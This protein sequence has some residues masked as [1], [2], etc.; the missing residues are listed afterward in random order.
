MYRKKRG[1]LGFGVALPVIAA[2]GI[3]TPTQG[4][5]ALLSYSAK[6]VCGD[7]TNDNIISPVVRGKYRTVINI[8]NPHN[9]PSNGVEFQKKAVIALSQLSPTPGTISPLVDEALRPDA[10][11]GVT[12]RDICNLVAPVPC[13]PFIEGFLV[14]HVPNTATPLDVVTVITGRSIPDGTGPV[15][16]TTGGGV[17]TIDFEEV[18]PKTIQ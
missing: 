16:T 5:A 13:V 10:A 14:I 7:V 2:M 18:T 17:S 6:F 4:Q 12:C 8:H 15:P 9:I 3:L 1:V 11:L